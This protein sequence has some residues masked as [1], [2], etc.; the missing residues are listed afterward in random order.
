MVHVMLFPMFKFLYFCIRTFQRLCAVL[1]ITVICSSLMPCLPSMFLRHL[2][3]DFEK[4]PFVPGING[5]TFVF[6]V[7]MCYISFAKS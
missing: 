1:S 7:H 5:I 6:I 4:V 3:N 2:L